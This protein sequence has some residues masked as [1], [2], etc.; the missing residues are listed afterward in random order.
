MEQDWDESLNKYATCKKTCSALT[1]PLWAC[2]CEHSLTSYN[3]DIWIARRQ[4]RLYTLQLYR[5]CRTCCCGC[6][7]SFPTLSQSRA[8]LG[9][10]AIAAMNSARRPCCGT[11]PPGIKGLIS[12]G[13]FDLVPLSSHRTSASI[14][15]SSSILTLDASSIG[16]N[17]SDQSVCV[18]V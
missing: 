4:S 17:H 7:C 18:C 16:Y 10:T 11:Q 15:N 2:S 6:S 14:D 5:V 9:L 1:L 13:S 3:T 8:V 12:C